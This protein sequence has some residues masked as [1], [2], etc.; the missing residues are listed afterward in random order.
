MES[1]NLA[2]K[3]DQLKSMGSSKLLK[4][5][6]IGTVAAVALIALVVGSVVF[7]YKRK[8][9]KYEKLPLLAN[10]YFMIITQDYAHSP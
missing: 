3:E 1:S 9:R 5:A 10:R 2:I 6:L 7:Y 4:I 8:P